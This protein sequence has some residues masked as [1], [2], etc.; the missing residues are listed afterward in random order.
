M[1]RFRRTKVLSP[2]A[3]EGI[4]SNDSGMEAAVEYDD[5]EVSLSKAW[6]C[7]KGEEAFVLDI[8]SVKMFEKVLAQFF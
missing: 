4:F 1:P 2:K 5:A 8:F 7:S 3:V 6:P